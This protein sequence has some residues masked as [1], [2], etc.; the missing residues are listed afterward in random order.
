MA[1]SGRSLL[2]LSF[3]PAGSHSNLNLPEVAQM[4]QVDFDAFRQW[5][6]LQ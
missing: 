3:V 6:Q 2:F 5:S 4:Q 1:S